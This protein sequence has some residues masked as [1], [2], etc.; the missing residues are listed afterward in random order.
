MH[1][2]IESVFNR[3]LNPRRCKCVI[4]NRD[5]FALA[6]DFRDG[7]QVDQLQQRIAWS[8]DPHHARVW[9]DRALEIVRIG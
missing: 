9:F 1:D 4:R 3:A 6:R 5:E 8:F 2:D 7:F